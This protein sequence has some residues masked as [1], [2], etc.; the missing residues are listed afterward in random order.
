MDP[1]YKLPEP[2][3]SVFQEIITSKTFQRLKNISQ[4]GISHYVFGRTTTRYEHSIGV[5]ILLRLLGASIEEQLSGLL[6]DI[7]HTPF[8]HV[9]DAIFHS[10]ESNFHETIKD[11]FFFGEISQILENYG[12]DAHYIFD[13]HNFKL[14][15][16]PLPNLC[17]D[18]VD[19]ALRDGLWSHKLDPTKYTSDL[20]VIA[21]EIAFSTPE[22]GKDF[23]LDYIRLD[24]SIWASPRELGAYEY[25]AKILVS[26]MDVGCLD[27]S[28]LIHGTEND[29]FDSLNAC[30][31]PIQQ[32]LRNLLSGNVKFE[33]ADEGVKVYPK[34]RYVDPLTPDGRV[35]E[36]FPEAR[37]A[38]RAHIKKL[39]EGY[40]I[41][42]VLD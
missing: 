15:E 27:K 20:T 37:A 25:F 35:S 33:L 40:V 4:G 11:K 13:E 36:L 9:I 29:V 30:P 17:A 12:F 5:A 8:S 2:Q 3:E 32:K 14:L 7:S 38:M 42:A 10:K 31:H 41:Q 21:G 23:A 18:R 19:Y 34:I 39:K 6:H 24:D 28:V 1:V 22:I 16:R 26:A